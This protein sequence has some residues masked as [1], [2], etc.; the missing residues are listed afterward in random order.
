MQQKF[1]FEWLAVIF[2]F[3][4][5]LSI[6]KGQTVIQSGINIL[7]YT[8]I[9]NQTDLQLGTATISEARVF[10]SPNGY[11]IIIVRSSDNY[12]NVYT[13]FLE[14][15]T[16]QR[17]LRFPYT[18]ASNLNLVNGIAYYPYRTSSGSIYQDTL[19]SYASGSAQNLVIFGRASNGTW[20][21]P[22]TII[23]GTNYHGIPIVNTGYYGIFSNVFYDLYMSGTYGLG[24]NF[25][26]YSYDISLGTLTTITPVRGEG[27][28]PN[29]VYY[30]DLFR[31]FSQYGYDLF[32]VW[33]STT[34][35]PPP[36]G[37]RIYSNGTSGANIV[38]FGSSCNPPIRTFFIPFFKNKIRSEGLVL[39]LPKSSSNAY[40]I[41]VLWHPDT[42]QLIL[43]Y[44][45]PNN[46]PPIPIPFTNGNGLAGFLYYNATDSSYYIFIYDYNSRAYKI[47]KVLLNEDFIQGETGVEWTNALTDNQPYT[48]LQYKGYY[49]SGSAINLTYRLFDISAIVQLREEDYSTPLGYSNFSRLLNC[50]YGGD[51]PYFYSIKN[52]ICYFTQVNPFNSS[53]TSS[54]IFI[55]N[56]TT[57][58]YYNYVLSTSSASAI[59]FTLKNSPKSCDNYILRLERLYDVYKYVKDSFFDYNCIATVY[60][61]PYQIYRLYVIDKNTNQVVYQTAG[62]KVV[63]SSFIIDLGT[64]PA[65]Q[66]IVANYLNNFNQLIS[67]GC[68]LNSNI[69]TCYANNLNTLPINVSFKVERKLLVGYYT[70]CEDNQKASSITFNCPLDNNTKEAFVSLVWNVEDYNTTKVLYADYIQNQI[71]ISPDYSGIA[72]ATIFFLGMTALG[73]FN[74]FVSIVLGIIALIVSAKLGLIYLSISS[75]IGLVLVLIIVKIKEENV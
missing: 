39:T 32:V 34:I 66:V 13:Y 36:Q 61:Q 43:N 71:S 40:L 51:N 23:T 9:L 25:V 64:Q 28:N 52:Q 62:F 47:R 4:I 37:I 1:K 19:V 27:L 38:L 68:G 72:V 67:Y 57:S 35:S 11:F 20:V 54:D 75:I 49:G 10:Y 31:Y 30:Y 42:F 55:Y 22:I 6:A 45:Y 29:N 16:V 46:S 5:A 18:F 59:S 60:L 33:C 56:L 48:I 69:I 58:S 65:T 44:Q 7:N 63:Q 50:T 24:S 15:A 70:L 2:A 74:P 12:L 41:A 17:V 21:N 14:N 8:V 26:A 53:Y 3:L 73:I